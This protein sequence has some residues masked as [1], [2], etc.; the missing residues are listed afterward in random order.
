VSKFDQLL[1]EAYAS[2]SGDSEPI[3]FGVI[4]HLQIIRLLRVLC[5]DR[6]VA[7]KHLPIVYTESSKPTLFPVGRLRA[8]AEVPVEA[9]YEYSLLYGGMSQ[10]HHEMDYFIDAYLVRNS[11][12]SG[13]GMMSN[14]SQFLATEMANEWIKQAARFSAWT[15][16]FTTGLQPVAVGII[17][18]VESELYA[19]QRDGTSRFVVQPMQLRQEFYNKRSVGELITPATAGAKV[20]HYE[21]LEAW[22]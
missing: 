4:S 6:N 15:K 8:S 10:R 21:P 2:I 9:S 14:S 13:R 20:E 1:M 12:I 16:I 11:R 5:Y 3:N 18:A 7:G 17:R 22:Y 19:A